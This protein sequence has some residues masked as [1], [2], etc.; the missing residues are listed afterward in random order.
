MYVVANL[1]A[2]AVWR[3]E[4]LSTLATTRLAEL[5]PLLAVL[6][7]PGDDLVGAGTTTR[8][9]PEARRPAPTAASLP[10]LAAVSM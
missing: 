9:T 4:P 7:A 3:G 6:A 5:A 1:G 2:E 8:A 10:Y